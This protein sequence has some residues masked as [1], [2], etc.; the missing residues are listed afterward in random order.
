[1]G[2]Y[3]MENPDILPDP[4]KYQG[5]LESLSTNIKAE[6]TGPNPKESEDDSAD[7]EVG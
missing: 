6:G 4:I 1:M 5:Q 3:N 7:D 2:E